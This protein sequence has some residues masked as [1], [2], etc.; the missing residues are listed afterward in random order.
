MAILKLAKNTTTP[1]LLTITAIA[2]DVPS[3]NVKYG[4]Q[5]KFIGHTP[6][7]PDACIFLAPESA[8]RQLARV[9]LTLDDA[10]GHTVAITR[11]GDYIDF[12]PVGGAAPIAQASPSTPAPAP[13]APAAPAAIAT[14][15]PALERPRKAEQW[16]KIVVLHKRC[17]K[18]VLTDVV[19]LLDTAKIGASP[20]SVSALTAQLFIEAIHA[21][22]H[23]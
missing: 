12:S 15:D 2:R 3:N 7:D 19:P 13:A 23:R 1:V 6:T 18:H 4:P 22:L 20:E 11:P 5:H 10:V 21:G 14:P 16:R 9:G 17:L 8:V